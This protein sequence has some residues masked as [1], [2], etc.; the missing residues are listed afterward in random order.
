MESKDYSG[1]TIRVKGEIVVK[2]QT[3]CSRL[4]M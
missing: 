4:D 1:F 2:S 3:L